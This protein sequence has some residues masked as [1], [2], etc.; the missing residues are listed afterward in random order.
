MH[1]QQTIKKECSYKGIGLH[2][3]NTSSVRFLPAAPDS[4]VHFIRTDLPGSP[5]I[6]AHIDHVTAVV[7]GTTITVGTASVHTVEHILSA[8]MGL[9][10]DN[11][12]VEIDANE[13]PV[14]DG[15]ARAFAETLLKSGLQEQDAPRRYFPLSGPVVYQANETVIRIDP[16][17]GFTVQ[18]QLTYDH[19]MISKQ[20][21]SFELIAEVTG[22]NVER[23]R[24]S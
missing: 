5:R 12:D 13:P 16:A 10:I 8:L 11:L 23:L 22:Q 7:R 15:S 20:E 18:C 19:P 9:G 4:G 21:V 2:T 24:E 14:A 6:P 3:G 1:K 17:P